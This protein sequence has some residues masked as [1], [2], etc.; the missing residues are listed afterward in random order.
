MR[1]VNFSIPSVNKAAVSI[2]TTLYDRRA[3][4]CTSTL[5]LINSLNHLAYLTTS[6]ARIRD[7]LTVDGGIER[8]VCILKEGRS[9]DLMEMWKWNLAFQCI[10]NIGVRGSENVRTRVVEADMVPVIATILDNYIQV[11]DKIRSATDAEPQ[12]S[13]A[14]AHKAQPRPREQVIR[15]SLDR[16]AASISEHRTTRRQAPPPSIEIPHPFSQDARQPDAGAMEITPSPQM[17]LTSPPER[18]SF[19]RETHSHRTL[20]PGGHRHR[21]I[22]PL[23]TAVPSMDTT[24]GFGLRP[25]RDADRLPSQ[26]PGLQNGLTSQ[27][28]S[29]TT[30]HT[31]VEAQSIPQ[32]TPRARRRP[33]VRQQRSTSGESDDGNTEDVVMGDDSA[34]P[35]VTESIVGLQ[36]GMEIES[37]T[38]QDAIMND[39]TDSHGIALPNP[40]EQAD[41]ET[42]NITHRSVPDGSLMN[43]AAQQANGAIT[44]SPTRTA[45]ATATPAANQ[46][47]YPYYLR[48]RTVPNA[49]LAA[50]PRDEDVLMALQLL[51]YVSKYCSLRSYFQN[52]H[53][54]PK[55]KIGKD[56]HLVDD[57]SGL[58]VPPTEP[59]EETEEYLLPDDFNIFPLVEKFTV[60]HHTKEMQYWACVVMRNLCRKDDSRGGI[61]QCAYYKCGKWEEFQRQF[62][63]CRRCRRTKYCSKECQKNAW[64]YHR[65]WCHSSP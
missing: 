39:G 59:T 60:R 36:A 57:P 16:S 17:V 44:L 34:E 6:S 47:P 51:A 25:V 41:A 38:D 2:T 26:V 18:T 5:P 27:P 30:P 31:A 61:R 28:D 11:V 50:M 9:K 33:S 49:V 22:Q 3:L 4:D 19:S 45:V 53:L 58:L 48:D 7:I 10:V 21:I 1:E 32:F 64:V 65:H 8:L 12:R 14:K 15:S 54:V 24:D 37:V 20:Q 23:A 40:S 55:L 52:T 63:K 42:F 62:A 56:I 13:S 29:P 43:P 35:N 46:I